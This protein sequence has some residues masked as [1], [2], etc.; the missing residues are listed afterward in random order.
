MDP[1]LR[2]LDDSR[3]V[4]STLG[5][6]EADWLKR[7]SSLFES[8]LR[9]A[10]QFQVRLDASFS[11]GCSEEY[12]RRYSKPRLLAVVRL[13]SEFSCGV[14]MRGCGETVSGGSLDGQGLTRGNDLHAKLYLDRVMNIEETV[15]ALE[16]L[17][18]PSGVADPITRAFSKRWKGAIFGGY[19]LLLDLQ[20]EQRSTV[21]NPP[22]PE[23]IRPR[24][25]RC[26]KWP[27]WGMMRV[28]NDSRRFMVLFRSKPATVRCRPRSERNRSGLKV[29]YTSPEALVIERLVSAFVP[30]PL[31]GMRRFQNACSALGSNAVDHVSVR[32]RPGRPAHLTVFRPYFSG[33]CLSPSNVNEEGKSLVFQVQARSPLSAAM[34]GPGRLFPSF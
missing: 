9:S 18:V 22:Y 1:S 2:F 23:G 8:E 28:G 13:P 24:W 4:L 14:S 15:E 29:E 17:D 7:L 27:G 25:R 10:C 26:W 21:K 16:I 19:R 6:S 30:A 31:F 33:S 12:R 34:D 11:G 32:L 5:V 3:A 20:F